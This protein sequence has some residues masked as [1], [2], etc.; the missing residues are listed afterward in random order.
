MGSKLQECMVT[1]YDETDGWHVLSFDGVMTEA[2]AGAS[3]VTKYPV[4]SGFEVADHTIRHNRTMSLDAVISNI[5][6]NTISIRTTVQEMFE[7][8]AIEVYFASSKDL[9]H[10]PEWETVTKHGR[11]AYDNDNF[12][13]DGSFIGSIADAL[14]YEISLEKVQETYQLIQ[15]LVERGQ[16]LHISTIRGVSYN[17][18]LTGYSTAADVSD[19]YSMKITLNL[20]ELVVVHQEGSSG[21]IMTQPST[22]KGS[23]LMLGIFLIVFVAIRVQRKATGGL[24]SGKGLAGILVDEPKSTVE[25]FE[26]AVLNLDHQFIPFSS[27]QAT[28]FTY[29]GTQ[30]TL[31]SLVW[32]S[33]AE[34]F[35][36]SLEWK[37]PNTG[38]PEVVKGMIMRPGTNIVRPYNTNMPSL[39]MVNTRGAEDPSEASNIRLIAVEQYE[40][41]ME[42][43]P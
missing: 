28:R 9:E 32:N 40:E 42:L 11:A 29:K 20:E 26:K 21:V 33:V 10:F 7:F 24:A 35:V 12:S 16:L 17:T 25:D 23:Y 8:V 15:Q 5:S 30:Y 1:W 4:D 31:G 18:V 38:N 3:T 37:D 19:A 36:S 43:V 6:L 14:S 2:H 34:A 27:K 13:E 22:A 39:V 41:I